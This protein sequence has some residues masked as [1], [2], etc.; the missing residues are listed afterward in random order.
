LVD[1]DQ[2]MVKF[3]NGN[4]ML[5]WLV[6]NYN[7]AAILLIRHPCAVVSSQLKFKGGYKYIYDHPQFDLPSFSG[8]DFFD[9]YKDI[10]ETIKEPEEN[11]AAMW[12]M[13][14]KSLLDDPL[15]NKG[16]HT[17]FYESL[18][19]NPE[20]ELSLIK[21]RFPNFNWKETNEDLRAPSRSTLGDKR[22]HTQIKNGN[23][24]DKWKSELTKSQINNIKAVVKRFNINLYV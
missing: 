16:W 22:L 12:C 23:Q 8:V 5:P 21:K 10:L 20:H 24:L 1:F 2:L 7:I 13:T 14:L 4:L 11:L 15:H 3:C 9:Q 19:E 6:E 17:L 18:V